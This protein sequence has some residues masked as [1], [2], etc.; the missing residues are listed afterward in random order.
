MLDSFC[1]N[2]ISSYDR[3]KQKFFILFYPQTI[4]YE[5]GMEVDKMKNFFKQ[6]GKAFCYLGTYMG[7]QGIAGFIM[8]VGCGVVIGYKSAA[9][10]ETNLA[11]SYV[12]EQAGTMV[13]NNMGV[14]LIINAI[15]AMAIYLVVMKIRKHKFTEE[16][17]IKKVGVKTIILAIAAAL[18]AICVIDYGVEL[19]PIP[20]EL[21]NGLVED[22][23][24]VA[25]MPLWQSI[26]AASIIV[27]IMEEIVFRGF[28]FSRLGKAMP[29]WIA[30][31]IT[32]IAFG[33]VHGQ[34]IWA[35]LAALTGVVFNIVR[36]K[37]DS[38]IPTIVMHM[39]NNSLATLIPE[40]ASEIPI[41]TIAVV[42]F[43]AVLLAISLY[44]IGR[45]ENKGEIAEVEVK[46]SEDIKKVA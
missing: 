31:A 43:G 38:I 32:S 2:I 11:T 23:G 28:M 27:P 33:L 21:M 8:L 30:V 18:G 16:V 39:V 45:D 13:E 35:L 34:M 29:T 4:R 3:F 12:M 41:P 1:D 5:N 7:C 46:V 26:L 44:F 37:T 20:E 19:L 6:L 40:S 22:T 36:I 25:E 17:A 10:G 9:S 24:K 14:A 42:I 15:L